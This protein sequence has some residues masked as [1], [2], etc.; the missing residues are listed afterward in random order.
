LITLLLAIGTL[1]MGL[2]TLAFTLMGLRAPV[3]SRYF[4]V[5]TASITGIAFIAYLIMAT[6]QGSTVVGTGEQAREFYYWRYIDWLF[7]TPLLLLDLALLALYRPGRKLGL[8]AAIMLLDVA[9]ILLGLWAGATVGAGRYVLFLL[10]T[11]AMIALL[12]L[13]VTQLFAAAAEQTPAVRSVFRTLAYLTVIL[14]S[15]Y[16][17]VWL[18]G[19]EGTNAIGQ[20]GEV[21]GFLVLDLLAKVGFGFLLLSNRRALEDISAQ[22]ASAA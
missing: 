5:I 14:W 11:A 22:R 3:G 12:Y 17:V 6:G 9:M 15:L 18:L 19:A 16:P 7:T 13:I 8:I 20:T 10:S 4:F 2:G 1:G 21:A